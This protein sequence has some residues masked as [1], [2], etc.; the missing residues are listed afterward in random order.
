MGMSARPP[1]RER[2]ADD[3][4]VNLIEAGIVMPMVLLV[5]FSIAEFATIFYVNLALQNGVSQATR[6]AITGSVLPGMSRPESI[7]AKMRQATPTLTILDT[8]FTF[9]HLPEGG[10]IWL[11]GTGPANS[12]EKVTVD[13]TW[14]IMTPLMRPF[15]NNNQITFRVESAMKNEGQIQL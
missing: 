8:A 3:K 12:V 10:S 7:R 13:Y 6:F 4:G 9:S 1:L 15:F 14:P 11:G 5:C 2:L